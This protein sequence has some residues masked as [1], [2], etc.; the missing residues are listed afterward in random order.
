VEWAS[1]A[2]ETASNQPILPYALI[3]L[4]ACEDETLPELWD[5]DTS[6]RSIFKSLVDTVRKNLVFKRHARLWMERGRSVDTLEDLMLCY[7]SSIKVF[8]SSVS[9]HST[10]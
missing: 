9:R 2:L 6:T 8:R 10:Y 1:A 3:V 7:F 5:S 4:N